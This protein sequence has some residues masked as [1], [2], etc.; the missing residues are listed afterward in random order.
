MFEEIVLFP[1]NDSLVGFIGEY[2]IDIVLQRHHT[3]FLP[4]VFGEEESL[5]MKAG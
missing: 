1:S 5:Y 2:Y 3:I 4:I